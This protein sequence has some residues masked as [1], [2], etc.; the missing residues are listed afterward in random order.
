MILINFHYHVQYLYY[1]EGWLI[2]ETNK[3]LINLVKTL[4]SLRYNKHKPWYKNM[5]KH[6]FRH[7]FSTVSSST[8]I[9][10]E[11]LHRE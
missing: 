5:S 10:H 7:Q 9:H 8:F 4:N 3:I 11:R 1:V 6:I 2:L